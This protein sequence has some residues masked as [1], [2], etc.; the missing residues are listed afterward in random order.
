MVAVG[1]ASASAA[2]AAVVIVAAAGAA[3]VGFV[4]YGLYRWLAGSATW[5]RG[6]SAR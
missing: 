4:G 2:S 6:S 5:S 3:A 1:G